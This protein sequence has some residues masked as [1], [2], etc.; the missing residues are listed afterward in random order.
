MEAFIFALSEGREDLLA[1]IL[2]NGRTLEHAAAADPGYSEVSAFLERLR[3]GGLLDNYFA[4][5]RSSRFRDSITFTGY[6]THHEL[7]HLFA[8]CDVGIFPSVVREAGPL[9]FLEAI[10]SGCLPMGTYMGGMAA[11]IDAV[12]DEL[13]SELKR[14]MSLSPD[15]TADDIAEKLPEA[16]LRAPEYRL[17]LAD[18]ARKHYD[19]SSVSAKLKNELDLLAGGLHQ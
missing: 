14:L 5:A 12:S 2:N 1:E 16:L 3:A 18:V 4:S 6:L 8:C 19:W 11:S 15:R 9:V 10:A 17:A 7:K 13:G